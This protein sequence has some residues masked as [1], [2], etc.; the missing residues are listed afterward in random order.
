MC[1]MQ[2]YYYQK[3]IAQLAGTGQHHFGVMKSN[4]EII[5]CTDPSL[6]G[7]IKPVCP[8][9]HHQNMTFRQLRRT[10]NMNRL[11]FVDSQG[12]TAEAEASLICASLEALE[13]L[14]ITKDE[15]TD[16]L[17]QIIQQKADLSTLYTALEKLKIKNPLDRYTCLFHCRQIKGTEFCNLIKANF[18]DQ[19]QDFLLVSPYQNVILVQQLRDGRTLAQAAQE[20]SVKIESIQ[21]E[22]QYDICAGISE[23]FNDMKDL[24]ESFLQAKDALNACDRECMHSVILYDRTNLNSLVSQLPEEVSRAYMERILTPHVR[25]ILDEEV[26][27]TVKTFL[28]HN[29]NIAETSR[30]LY[31]NRNT[32]NYR[33]S[34]IQEE[35]GLDLR[36][37]EDAIKFKA[38]LLMDD[39]F[40]EKGKQ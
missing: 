22:Y 13:N 12:E 5:A 38:A 9:G 37:F 14:L 17:L 21:K 18:A 40:Q 25:E 32:L 3:L 33:L 39:H 34:R 29:L 30:A 35:T 19:N 31:I 26:T 10:E 6:I 24:R 28:D 36:K 23:V 2:D 1:S 20:S 16:Y 8:T 27:L 7:T 11:V 4:G 15:Q